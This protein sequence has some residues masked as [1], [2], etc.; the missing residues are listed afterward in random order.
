MTHIDCYQA[1]HIVTHTGCYQVG[2]TLS[3]VDCYQKG[4]TVAQTMLSSKALLE[5]DRTLRNHAETCLN[6][7]YLMTISVAKIA[8][9]G[10]E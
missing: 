7:R 6:V 8:Q 2:Y 4:Y 10:D 3:H 1:G 9:H 5:P